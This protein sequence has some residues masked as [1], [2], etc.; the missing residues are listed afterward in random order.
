MKHLQGLEATAG[1]DSLGTW[2]P[3]ARWQEAASQTQSSEHHPS[4][5]KEG[6]LGSEQH[7][8][9]GVRCGRGLLKG[10]SS[11]EHAPGLWNLQSGQRHGKPRRSAPAP[12]EKKACERHGGTRRASLRAPRCIEKRFSS[13][14]CRFKCVAGW[15]PPVGRGPGNF[16]NQTRRSGPRPSVGSLSQHVSILHAEAAPATAGLGGLWGHG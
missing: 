10:K 2:A 8:G 6:S 3:G 9:E 16:T 12:G 15:A 13:L 4:T 7:P 11:R 1:Q 5:P 14:L